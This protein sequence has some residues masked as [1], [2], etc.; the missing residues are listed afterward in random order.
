MSY[1][2]SCIPGYPNIWNFLLAFIVNQWKPKT[3]ERQGYFIIS[4]FHFFCLQCFGNQGNIIGEKQNS[5]APIQKWY[6]VYLDVCII[7]KLST[8]ILGRRKTSLNPHIVTF[9][10]IKLNYNNWERL[11]KFKKHYYK[12]KN[13]NHQNDIN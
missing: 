5:L 2:P 11:E 6:P 7:W 12:L 9:Y 4:L 10:Y 13:S 8:S 1:F 3:V